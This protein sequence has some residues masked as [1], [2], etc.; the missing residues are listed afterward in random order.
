MNVKH[1]GFEKVLA[2]IWCFGFE[3]VIAN[4]CQQTLLDVL[5]SEI[6]IDVVIWPKISFFK[7]SQ[8]RLVIF[9]A[10]RL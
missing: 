4:K 8:I 10:L 9:V 3:S 2:N 5:K 1:F 7:Q 6:K